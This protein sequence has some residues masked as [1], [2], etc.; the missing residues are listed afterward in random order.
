M[1]KTIVLVISFL[2]LLASVGTFAYLYYQNNEIQKEINSSSESVQKLEN[3]INNE[4][5]QI[6]EKEDEYEKLKEKVQ[7]NLEELSIWEDI[8]ERLNNSLS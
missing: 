6:D 5:Q 2:L 3:T 1:R 7:E 4:K 8:K